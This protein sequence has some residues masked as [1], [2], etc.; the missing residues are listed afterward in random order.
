MLDLS[1][2]EN[3][4][5]N[6][7]ELTDDEELALTLNELYPA[8]LAE[9]FRNLS[10]EERHKYFNLLAEDKAAAVIEELS[11]QL[12][13]ELLGSIE[14]EKAARIIFSMP[15]D[16]VADVLG[17]LSDEDTELYLAKLPT[18][19]SSQIR[20]LMSYEED[21]AG[22]IMNSE[23]L[24]VNKDMSVG[25]TLEY[26][27]AKAETTNIDFYYIYVVDN[28]NR[29]LGVLSLRALITSPTDLKVEQIMKTDIIR[30]NVHD[31]QEIVADTL[32]KYGFLAL[33]VVDN[34]EKL[35]GIIT[36]DDAQ[37]VTEE[38]TTEDIYASS[39]I[40]TDVLD[41][42]DDILSAK[43]SKAVKAR[44]PWLLVTLVG[45]FVAVNVANHFDHTLHALPVIAIFM[46]LLAGLGGNIG[47]QSITLMVRGLSTGQ[48][49]LNEVMHHLFRELKV[50]FSIGLLFGV[51]VALTTWG[52]KNNIVLGAVVG[53]AMMTNMTLA[54]IL[55]TI[56]PFVLKR[57]GVDP[58]VAS[59]PFIA[60]AIDVIGLA[61]YF[62]LVSLTL[63]Y[64][65]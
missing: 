10:C 40:S 11:P 49:A 44:T 30:V 22:G 13:V 59:G 53:V 3:L 32:M 37:E 14:Q 9:I 24:K 20:E 26:T 35:K 62:M 38:E 28:L 2:S 8:D 47:T 12:Q 55:G 21:T 36:W 7:D 18:R 27:R 63:K 50:G 51:M 6:L 64:L 48:V 4:M 61:N 39:G 23:V 58:A 46:P 57:F 25:E 45:E 17:D 56:T 43:I 31:D 5:K 65:V 41:D 33:P 42:E 1:N 34:S 54:T 19:V 52:W 29:L 15:H 60:T 16:S